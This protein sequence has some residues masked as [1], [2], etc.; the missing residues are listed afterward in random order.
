MRIE[1]YGQV[2]RGGD[3]GAGKWERMTWDAA[4]RT[5]VAKLLYVKKEFGLQAVKITAGG[6]SHV[7]LLMGRLRRADSLMFGAPEGQLNEAR[8]PVK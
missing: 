7:R 6:S 2:K 5:I 3:R 8:I 1:G 4:F